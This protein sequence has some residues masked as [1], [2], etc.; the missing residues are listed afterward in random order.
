M[1]EKQVLK[2]MDELQSHPTFRILE[3]ELQKTF[4]EK[5][6]TTKNF[7]LIRS[8]IIK[9]D[10]ENITEW[11]NE[12]FTLLSK[13]KEN[14]SP[15]LQIIANYFEDLL[16][17]LIN[18]NIIQTKAEWMLKLSQL[19]DQINALLLNSSA[20]ISKYII[21][22]KAIS[23]PSNIDLFTFTTFCR[24]SNDPLLIKKI[25]SIL[26]NFNFKPDES[27][28]IKADLYSLTPNVALSLHSLMPEFQRK[29]QKS[30]KK[31]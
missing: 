22:K 30:I 12:I 2:I 28:N 19:D 1:W 11:K 5:E 14:F 23:P 17:K 18:K 3:K 25:Y 16:N 20:D 27:G 21:N 29:V 13:A 31:R 24:K 8:K 26:E 10:Y 9:K 7:D 6:I 4:E 15:E